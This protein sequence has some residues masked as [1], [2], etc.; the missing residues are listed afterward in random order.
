[1]KKGKMEMLEAG[2]RWPLDSEMTSLH[3]ADGL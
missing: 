1:M 3:A 2:K